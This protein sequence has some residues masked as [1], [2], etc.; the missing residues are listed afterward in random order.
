MLPHPQGDGEG[1]KNLC[2]SH[3]GNWRF[4]KDYTCKIGVQ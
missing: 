3:C 4:G 2:Y 1:D